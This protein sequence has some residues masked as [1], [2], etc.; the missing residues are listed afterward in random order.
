MLSEAVNKSKDILVAS[1]L[2]PPT[3]LSPFLSLKT[4][5]VATPSISSGTQL[6]AVPDRSSCADGEGTSSPG[7]ELFQR[8]VY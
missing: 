6:V 5:S 2:F 8:S 4:L 1:T 3:A 7:P